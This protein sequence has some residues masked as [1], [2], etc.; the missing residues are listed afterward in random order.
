[1]DG[2]ASVAEAGSVIFND[3]TAANYGRGAE[4]QHGFTYRRA[5]DYISAACLL[6]HAS[7]FR[8]VRRVRNEG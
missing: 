4:A 2:S 3:G 7:A 6:V 1:M 5:A 8:E